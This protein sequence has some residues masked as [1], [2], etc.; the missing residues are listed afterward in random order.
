[1]HVT[2]GDFNGDGATDFVVANELDGAGTLG[3]VLGRGDGTF[4]EP[5]R[6]ASGRAWFVA[7]ADVNEDGSLDLV[8]ASPA[9]GSVA[10]LIGDGLGG[11]AEPRY[12]PAGDEPRS[13]VVGRLNRDQSL[14]LAVV[15]TGSNAI[16]IL[17]GD[18]RGGFSGPEQVA[19]SGTPSSV[20]AADFNGDGHDD[21]AIAMSEA[22]DLEV[23]LGDA[24]GGYGV[25]RLFPA[26]FPASVTAGDVDRD[27]RIDLVTGNPGTAGVAVLI[28]DGLGSFGVA[29]FLPLGEGHTP[30][31]VIVARLDDDLV[32]DVAASDFTD[33]NVV[34]F[35]GEGGGRF[36]LTELIKVPNGPLGMASADFDGNGRTDLVTSDANA[37]SATVL[38]NGC[39]G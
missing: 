7:A 21:L 26:N 35:R 34:L 16:A 9:E 15:A 29:E 38:L 20:I 33:D 6:F 10:V 37:N 1:M 11:F 24:E 23:L 32:P 3:V 13:L 2:T 18:G 36:A 19:T 30:G 25:P 17:Y 12:F 4:G 8:G 27:G 28:G 14:D 22:Q 39:G 5:T 31:P